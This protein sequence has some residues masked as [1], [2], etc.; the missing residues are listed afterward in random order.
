[1]PLG[2]FGSNKDGPK[3]QP[4]PSIEKGKKM[5]KEKG[6]SS[7]SHSGNDVKGSTIK[8]GKKS[9]TIEKKIAEGLSS[10]SIFNI[11]AKKHPI[12]RFY[13]LNF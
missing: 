2:I 12:F 4:L 10:L 5:K 11:F 13:H 1:M 7:S 3:P 8:M 9:Y 6:V